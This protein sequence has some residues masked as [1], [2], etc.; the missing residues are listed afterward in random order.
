MCFCSSIPAIR[1]QLNILILQHVKER[2][3]A[4]NTARI[5][6][7]ALSNCELLV[8]QTSGLRKRVEL[9]QDAAI[10]YPGPN[11]PLL[12][13]I[14]PQQRPSELVILD[15]TW[16]HARTLMRD[17]PILQTLPRYQLLPE[18]PSQYQLRREP[19][20]QSLSTLEATVQALQILEPETDVEGLMIAFQ[21]MVSD[22]LAHK[23]DAVRVRSRPLTG[24][25]HNIPKAILEESENLVV[26]YGET[27]FG[28]KGVHRRDQSLIYVVARRMRTEPEVFESAI[29]PTTE[30]PTEFLRLTG[31]PDIMT[32]APTH[33]EFR[34]KWNSFLK[35]TD[36]LC[37]F[38]SGPIRGLTQLGAATGARP[39]ILLKSVNLYRDCK[40]LDEIM[41][42]AGLSSLATGLQGR[43]GKRL[44][45]A[46]AYLQYLRRIDGDNDSH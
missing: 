40:T 4:F 16:H 39:P 12:N 22:Q 41:H 24:A 5:V 36:I 2:F 28:Q 19:T 27:A 20:E 37:S 21:H 9:R 13:S 17:I 14:A 33:A 30:L 6:R 44:G 29:R 35:P 45:N 8:D 18:R 7:E 46:I 34:E 23:G 26:V 38:H 25:R 11:V 43:A 31:L 10:L 1:N 15:G 42:K 3:H 32:T